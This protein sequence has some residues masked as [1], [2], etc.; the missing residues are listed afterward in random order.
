MGRHKERGRLPKG[1]EEQVKQG[2]SGCLAGMTKYACYAE[3]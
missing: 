2:C 1:R 3:I